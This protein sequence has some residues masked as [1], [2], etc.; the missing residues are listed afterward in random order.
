M[1]GGV[2]FR[3]F[4]LDL[5]AVVFV[6]LVMGHYGIMVPEAFQTIGLMFFIFTV[7]IQAGPG[8]FDSFKK[9]GRQFLGICLLLVSIA[10]LLSFTLSRLFGL[11]PHLGVGI[12]NGALTSTSG[13]GSCH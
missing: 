6:A 7:G 3:G 13:P 1:L 4:S 8:F 11:D 9:S 2:K 5:S 10:A 12:F